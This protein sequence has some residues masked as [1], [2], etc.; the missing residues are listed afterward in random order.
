MTDKK[1]CCKN[2]KF[3]DKPIC[4]R[5]PPARIV[6]VSGDASNIDSKW[7]TAWPMVEEDDYCG[8]FKQEHD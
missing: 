7:F 6:D 1:A 5:Y 8:E 3:L 2:C 4:R